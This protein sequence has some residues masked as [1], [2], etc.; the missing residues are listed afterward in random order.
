MNGIHCTELVVGTSAIAGSAIIVGITNPETW[1]SIWEKGGVA[2]VVIL[3]A[4]LIGKATVPAVANW[5]KGYLEGLEKRNAETQRR[6]EE[7]M[8]HSQ[9]KFLAELREERISRQ[10]TEAAF[11]EMLQGHKTETIA[12]IKEQTGCVRELV[13]QLQGRPCQALQFKSPQP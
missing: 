13:A 4:F 2:L 8:D 5:V 6:W 10:N 12:A 11:R 1:A 7:R 3:A 9:D